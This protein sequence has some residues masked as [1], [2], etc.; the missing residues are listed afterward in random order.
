MILSFDKN[1]KLGTGSETKTQGLDNDIF[2]ESLGASF[3][4]TALN[5]MSQEQSRKK[6][7]KNKLCENNIMHA[8][9]QTVV[10]TVL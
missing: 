6:E 10:T 9:M 3:F 2:I 8:S 7:I 5:Q 4:R 1:E